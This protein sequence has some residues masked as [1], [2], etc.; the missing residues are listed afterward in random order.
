VH[1]AKMRGGQ[2]RNTRK[3]WKNGAQRQHGLDA[4]ATTPEQ[5][6]NKLPRSLNRRS[7]FGRFNT[8]LGSW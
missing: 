1:R 7:H 5:L 8:G 3:V 6:R 4:L 2:C